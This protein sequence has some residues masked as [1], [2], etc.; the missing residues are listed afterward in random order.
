MAHAI[1]NVSCEHSDLT[2]LVLA[3]GEMA[4]ETQK[5]VVVQYGTRTK[6]VSFNSSEGVFDSSLLIE[7]ARPL[8]K[9]FLP[10]VAMAMQASNKEFGE[11]IDVEEEED[12][13]YFYVETEPC[14][15]KH[16]YA[17]GVRS[18]PSRE[19]AGCTSWS[20]FCFR[21]LLSEKPE[22]ILPATGEHPSG[23]SSEKMPATVKVILN[24]LRHV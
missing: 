13:H 23:K 15:R 3:I 2:S 18:W 22:T 9:D 10:H 6:I 21:Y 20:I 7:V 19:S 14:Q 11:W 4:E 8:F 24:S 1:G 17:S 5:R 12:S 16:T